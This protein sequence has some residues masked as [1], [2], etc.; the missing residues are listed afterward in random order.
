MINQ[1]QVENLIQKLPDQSMDRVAKVSL[2]QSLRDEEVKMASKWSFGQVWKFALVPAIAITIV[3]GGVG[4]WLKPQATQS[5][6]LWAMKPSQVLAAEITQKAKDNMIKPGTI[7]HRIAKTYFSGSR[8]VLTTETFE[9]M[10]S[11]KYLYHNV[12]TDQDNWTL[13]KTDEYWT[14]DAKKKIIYKTV[15]IRDPEIELQPDQ[16]RVSISP[17]ADNV[18]DEGVIVPGSGVSEGKL[19]GRDVYMF[20]AYWE[21]ALKSVVPTED[22]MIYDK[23]T[24]ELLELKKYEVENG[25]KKLISTT[26]YELTESLPKTDDLVAKY[27]DT[28]PLDLSGYKIMS[29]NIQRGVEDH[30]FV[31]EQSLSVE[32]TPISADQYI[33]YVIPEGWKKRIDEIDAY[34]EIASP[35]HVQELSTV[36]GMSITLTSSSWREGSLDPKIEFNNLKTGNVDA[37]IH[38]ISEVVID[39]KPAMRYY[40]D[41]EG[42][43]LAY[44]VIYAGYGWDI[45]FSTA[46]LFEEKKYQKVID[47]FLASVK[48]KKLDTNTTNPKTKVKLYYHDQNLDPDVQLCETN[49]FIEQDIDKTGSP[50][51]ETINA[52]IRSGVFEQ[53]DKFVLESINL[54]NDGTLVLQFPF[55]GGFTTGGSCR[56][57]MMTDQIIK[58][59]R[60][61][62]EVKNVIF[63][64]RVFEPWVNINLRGVSSQVNQHPR[65]VGRWWWCRRARILRQSFGRIDER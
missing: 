26:V 43:Q 55:V 64:P 32:P 38:D 17:V 16:V 46:S 25:V 50:I 63:E 30:G 5:G 24:F 48:F 21:S 59:A 62:D 28:T 44:Y 58:T 19:N 1:E 29:K 13:N 31:E 9:D 15:Y 3:I 61:F 23:N 7:Y 65:W 57:G 37:G 45:R 34:L 14:I 56:I 11:P 10:D 20:T 2:R 4:V 35:D 52:L 47:Q 39:S 12:G 51:K 41:Y 6:I 18:S 42:H 54:K 36:K 53:D 8:D 40:I 22:L 60:Q 33:D 49:N 27:F